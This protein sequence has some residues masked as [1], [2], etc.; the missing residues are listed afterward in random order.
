LFRRKKLIQSEVG[1]FNRV[2]NEYFWKRRKDYFLLKFYFKLK[3]IEIEFFL[4]AEIFGK[5][6]QQS[7]LNN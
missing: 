4:F 2:L 1:E 3:L 6:N 5:K 7:I